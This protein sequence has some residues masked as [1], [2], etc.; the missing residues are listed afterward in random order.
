MT[1]RTSNILWFAFGAI[2]LLVSFY[3]SD[4]GH[5]HVAVFTAVI[6]GFACER[7]TR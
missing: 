1:R 5:G 6:G 3:L 2:L 4:V 7:Y